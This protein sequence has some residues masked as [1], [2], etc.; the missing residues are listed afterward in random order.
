M[1]P[2]EYSYTGEELVTIKT[3]EL[4][5]LKV[6]IE[7]AIENATIRVF[8]EK[9]EW[10]DSEG[11]PVENPSKED[12]A[13]GKVRQITNIKETFNP[14]NLRISYDPTKLTQEMLLAQEL[15]LDFHMRNIKEG[16]AKP[17]S[18]LIDVKAD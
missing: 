16:I 17:I 2:H 3:K 6:A 7:Q 9:T 5:L 1:N 4:N 13:F 18:E 15:L 11:N 12:I 14:S 8:D 10:L